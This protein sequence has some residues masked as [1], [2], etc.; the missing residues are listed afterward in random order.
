MNAVVLTPRK[1]S[2]KRIAHNV[3]PILIT[4]DNTI[5]V[6]GGISVIL[7]KKTNEIAHPGINNTNKK[8]KIILKNPK[9]VEIMS[10]IS[11][12]PALKC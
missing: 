1:I 7:G 12:S 6:T 5:L 10:A 11:K 2:R 9:R 4:H 8:P 3:D